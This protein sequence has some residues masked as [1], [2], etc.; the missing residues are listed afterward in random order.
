[1]HGISPK[2]REDNYSI[3]LNH[4]KLEFINPKKAFLKLIWPK[5]NK[6]SE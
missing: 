5:A 3:K 4:W 2:R 1:M 6:N